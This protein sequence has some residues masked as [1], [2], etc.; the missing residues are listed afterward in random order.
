[1]NHKCK[2]IISYTFL[3]PVESDASELLK[4]LKKDD[5]LKSL[6]KNCITREILSYYE[7]SDDDKK[8]IDQQWEDHKLECE[9]CSFKE[10]SDDCGM[11]FNR[12]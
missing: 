1:M 9:E 2:H 3:D 4:Q 10:C 12:L 5:N 6:F 11:N 7:L 8:T